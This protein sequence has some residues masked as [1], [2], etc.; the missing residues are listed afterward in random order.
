MAHEGAA[1]SRAS[2][3]RDREENRK[4]G[5]KLNST[6]CCSPGRAAKGANPVT[7]TKNSAELLLCG[8]FVCCTGIGLPTSC[9]PLPS[10]LFFKRPP[11]KGA[12]FLWGKEARR[13]WFVGSAAPDKRAKPAPTRFGTKRSWVQIPSPRPKGAENGHFCL[14]SAHFLLFFGPSQRVKL[15]IWG[16]IWGQNWRQAVFYFL[17]L[18]DQ[19][20]IG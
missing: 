5:R 6:V 20:F 13:R 15:S 12:A 8:V 1:R 14:F 16:Q 2:G 19:V 4:H 9:V 17:H 18:T 7:S 10:A 3:L 11:Q